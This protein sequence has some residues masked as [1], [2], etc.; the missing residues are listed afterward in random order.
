MTIH[1]FNKVTR[2]VV[3]T[4]AIISPLFFLFLILLYSGA[5]GLIEEPMIVYAIICFIGKIATIMMIYREI[6]VE[7]MWESKIKIDSEGIT[8]WSNK[9]TARL[10]WKNI[11]MVSYGIHNRAII[12][13]RRY[14]KGILGRR[15]LYKDITNDCIFF[16]LRSGIYKEIRKYYNGTIIREE[17][18]KKRRVK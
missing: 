7:G 18:L 5:L 11:N 13:S 10:E 6:I 17:K 4:I 1:L 2:S 15:I 3:Y 9:K 8:M 14:D 16:E 12:F